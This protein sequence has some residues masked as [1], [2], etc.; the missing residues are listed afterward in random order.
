LLAALQTF[1]SGKTGQKISKGRL[2]HNLTEENVE[3]TKD[4]LWV[5][6]NLKLHRL[7]GLMI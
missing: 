6:F 1:G 3:V 5:Y 7:L 2:R 4:I